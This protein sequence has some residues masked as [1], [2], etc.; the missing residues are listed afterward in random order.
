MHTPTITI[1]LPIYNESLRIAEGIK[2]AHLLKKKLADLFSDVQILIVD[3]GSTD[4]SLSLI[5][6]PNIDILQRPHMGKGATVRS[7]LVHSTAD[8]VLFSDIDWSVPVDT[9][10]QLIVH[11]LK[12]NHPVV[13][14]SREINGATRI[15]EPPWRHILGKIFNRWVQWVL[16]AG[17]MDTQCGCKLIHRSA[18]EACAPMLQ[19]DGW[20]FDVELLL[21]ANLNGIQ[22]S[23][24]PVPWIYQPQSKIRLWRDG[25]QMAQAVLRMKQRLHL[26]N[27]R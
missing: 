12:N 27:F 21:M 15:A 20:A 22:I 10:Y 6:D 3:D 19:E 14:A 4:T 18:I 26:N 16:L 9:V 11:G 1:L 24:F 25:I 17:Y 23:E 2:Q 13:I 7:G 5:N 8:W